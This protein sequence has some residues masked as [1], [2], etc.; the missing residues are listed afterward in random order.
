MSLIC[1]KKFPILFRTIFSVEVI[2]HGN[3]RNFI[4]YRSSWEN[5]EFLTFH[6]LC[7]VTYKSF[8]CWKALLFQ[9][10]PPFKNWLGTTLL[11]SHDQ[12]ITI[13]SMTCPLK[14][15]FKKKECLLNN[16]RI[17]NDEMRLITYTYTFLFN[18]S[19]QID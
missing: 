14:Y 1:F 12:M 19:L 15:K 16:K 6:Y 11:K 7:L 17:N 18:C 5:H 2:T 4:S 13:F 10:S 8:N 9:N 3:I